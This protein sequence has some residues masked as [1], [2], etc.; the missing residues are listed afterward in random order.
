MVKLRAT[1]HLVSFFLTKFTGQDSTRL[2][3][4]KLYNCILGLAG[5]LFKCPN[6][7]E[8]GLVESKRVPH[9]NLSTDGN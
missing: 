4:V 6:K 2:E 1:G 8:A 3:Q 7:R 9:A 5:G